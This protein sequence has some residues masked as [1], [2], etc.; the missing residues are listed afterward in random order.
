M[1]LETFLYLLTVIALGESSVPF[2][3]VHSGTAALK[4]EFPHQALLGKHDPE[5]NDIVWFCGGTLITEDTVMT[6]AHCVPDGKQPDVVRFGNLN[7]NTADDDKDTQQFEII[8]IERFPKFRP[9]YNDIALI[10]LK[11]KVTVT[12]YVMP[13]CLWNKPD[14]PSGI[15]LQASGFGKTDNG[16]DMSPILNKVSLFEVTNDKCGEIWKSIMRR[17]ILDTH[18]C[19]Y[20]ESDDSMDTCEGDSGGPLEMKLKDIDSVVPIVVGVTSFGMGC[21]S[22]HPGVYTRVSSFIDWIKEKVPEVET[23]PKLCSIKYK[24]VRTA[25]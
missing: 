9:R 12:K 19:A 17:G 22:E 18:L 2:P 15:K 7:K 3:R 25:F 10:K 4:G 5:S 11:K 21:G 8:S 20:D 6:A 1:T 14:L 13:A 23:D 24:E 16:G